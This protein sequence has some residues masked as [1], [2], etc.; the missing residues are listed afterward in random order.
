MSG[1]ENVITPAGSP[2]IQFVDID[3]DH[4]VDCF[5]SDVS[6]DPR[7]A[8]GVRFY[9][10]DGT[11]RRPH[12]IEDEL[13]NPVGFARTSINYMMFMFADIDKDGDVDFYY[14]GMYNYTFGAYD[15]QTCLNTGTATAA[16]YTLYLNEHNY[17]FKNQ[18]TFYD[19]SKDGLTDYFRIDNYNNIT[20]YWKNN[21]TL[22]SPTFSMDAANAPVFTNGLPARITDLNGDGAAEVFTAS[23]QFS[24]LAPVAAI[25]SKEIIAGGRKVQKLSSSYQA[26][27][28]TY[29]WEWNGKTIDGQQKATVYALQSGRYTLF[30]TGECGTGV[31]LPFE[32]NYENNPAKTANKQ[33]D[34]ITVQVTNLPTVSVRTYPN[35]FTSELL[36]QLPVTEGTFTIKM[37]DAQGRIMLTQKTSSS[38]LRVGRSLPGGTYFL[39]VYLGNEL[40]HKSTVIKQ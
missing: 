17:D 6:H 30:V 8:V 33:A 35:P 25:K 16:S 10:N 1:F 3:G 28:Y 5:I 22:N 9:R 21:G 11:A 38:K 4:D 39:E 24:T 7:P 2:T 20:E 37:T 29:R 19:W 36:I 40:I 13:N 27:N 12:F 31:S 15:Q 26:D 32:I 34:L 14:T 23:G 18:R